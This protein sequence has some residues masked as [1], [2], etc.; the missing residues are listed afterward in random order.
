MLRSDEGPVKL[1]ACRLHPPR[2]PPARFAAGHSFAT[3]LLMNGTDLRE[4]QELPGHKSV[5]TTMIYPRWKFGNIG[6]NM[7]IESLWV[8]LSQ[9]LAVDGKDWYTE[10][11]LGEIVGMMQPP[12]ENTRTSENEEQ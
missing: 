12:L 6:D 2:E 7:E 9:Q 10:I 4:I 11:T 5:E 3:H 8:E 1:P